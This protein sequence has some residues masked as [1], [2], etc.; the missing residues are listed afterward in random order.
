MN[1]VAHNAI[2]SK[3][4]NKHIQF[5]L[6]KNQTYII[7]NDNS[8]STYDNIPFITILMF[9]IFVASTI[10][11]Y[12]NEYYVYAGFFGL[13]TVAFAIHLMYIVNKM[14]YTQ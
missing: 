11:A 14:Q 5:D 6:S 4:T 2:T 7:D 1:P 13:S 12:V 9:T 3:K 8:G 10:L